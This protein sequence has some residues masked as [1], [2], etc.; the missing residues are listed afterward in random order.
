MC[1]VDVQKKFHYNGKITYV[2]CCPLLRSS[3]YYYLLWTFLEILCWRHHVMYNVILNT[4]M[5]KIA[6][7]DI[8]YI[9]VILDICRKIFLG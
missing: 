1:T 2:R 4:C 9:V 3:D 7:K 8:F 6:E 5:L